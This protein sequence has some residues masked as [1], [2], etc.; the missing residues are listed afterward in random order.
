MTARI[1]KLGTGIA[2]PVQSRALG[3]CC[4]ILILIVGAS[5]ATLTLGSLGIA[6]PDLFASL[7]HT[8]TGKTGFVLERLRGPRLVTAIGVGA[9]LGLAGTLFQTVT[10][11]PLG[12]PDIIGLGAGAGAGV[13]VSTLFLN[14]LIPTPIGALAGA[15]LAIVIVHLS[16]GRGFASPARVIIAGI[17]VSAIAFAITQY[18]VSIGLRDQASQLA[19][20]LAG[21]LNAANWNDALVLGATLLVVVPASAALSGDLRLMEMG[22]SLSDSLGARSGRTRTIAILLSVVAAAGAVTAAGPIAF[23]A[24]TAPQ[25]AKRATRSPGANLVAS[26]LTGAL[27]MV[28]ADLSVQQL[29]WADGLPV[30]VL[31]AG[32]GGL[33]L[34]YLLIHEWK[35]G[36]V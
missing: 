4:A 13:A 28:V 8:P 14:G 33:Y 34:G 16:T 2:L 31:T 25:I 21:S 5:I 9:A 15:A 32:V 19:A 35:K 11:N 12:S 1:L 7:L 36:R 6:L 22:D 29:D 24:L 23:V 3:Y 10:R 27:I 17:G 30:G 20:Y 26:A 18:V